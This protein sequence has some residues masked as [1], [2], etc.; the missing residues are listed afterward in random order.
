MSEI[1]VSKSVGGKGKVSGQCELDTACSNEA[2]SV[3]STP[4]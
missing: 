1:S 4:A 3:R 2:R